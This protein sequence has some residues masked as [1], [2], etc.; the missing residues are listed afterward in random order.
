MSGESVPLPLQRRVRAPTRSVEF[1][2][3][4]NASARASVVLPHWR[5]PSSAT[6][7]LRLKARVI[8]R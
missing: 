6:T 2:R 4:P 1:A 5:A 3:L 7:G 8:R